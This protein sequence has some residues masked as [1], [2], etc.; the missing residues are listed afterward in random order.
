MAGA[1]VIL[2][3]DTLFEIYDQLG[4]FTPQERA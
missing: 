3:E 1:P 2:G 4:P